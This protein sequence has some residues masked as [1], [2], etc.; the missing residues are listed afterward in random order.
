MCLQQVRADRRDS[1]A[2]GAWWHQLM[3]KGDCPCPWGPLLFLGPA[4]STWLYWEQELIR[5]MRQGRI[6]SLLVQFLDKPMKIPEKMYLFYCDNVLKSDSPERILKNRLAEF[7][8]V[9]YEKN[10]LC[11][12]HRV[13]FDDSLGF[14]FTISWTLHVKNVIHIKLLQSDEECLPALNVQQLQEEM[15]S[16]LSAEKSHIDSG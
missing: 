8:S 12:E 7:N 3:G 16:S 4:R 5:P 14:F 10:L 11:A 9:N 2:T 13:T 15:F 1:G 6:S